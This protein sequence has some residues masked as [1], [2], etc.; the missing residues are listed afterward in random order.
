M[1]NF[2]IAGLDWQERVNW[3]RLRTYRTERARE[4]MKAHGL[5]AMLLMYDENMR[6]VTSTL[7]PGWNRLKPGLRYAM[8]CG[9]RTRADRLRAG[10][11][12]HPASSATAR[13]F[14]RRTCATHTRGSRARPDRRSAQQ[15]DEVHQRHRAGTEDAGVEGKPLG[16]DFIDINM[17]KAFEEA[18]HHL[19]RRHD[20]DDGGAGDQEPR[21]AEGVADRR[22]DLRRAALRV[23]RSS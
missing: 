20:P 4:R 2:G 13:G 11:H 19:D 21:R 6:Y 16:V 15:V 10:R 9:R 12:R 18:R 17:I 22:L 8:L 23:H 1:A 7:T 14:P 3:D 5:G